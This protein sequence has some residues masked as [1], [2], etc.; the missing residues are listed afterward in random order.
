MIYEVFTRFLNRN[1]ARNKKSETN[2]FPFVNDLTELENY[3]KTFLYE[4][5]PEACVVSIPGI[6]WNLAGLK[7]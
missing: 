3:V 1:K 4:I 6:L 5:C 2:L 7:P